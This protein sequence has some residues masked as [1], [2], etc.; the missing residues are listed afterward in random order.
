MTFSCI[1]THPLSVSL[2]GLLTSKQACV[3]YVLK[4]VFKMVPRIGYDTISDDMFKCHVLYSRTRSSYFHKEVLF[5]FKV[6]KKMTI[7]ETPK[8]VLRFERTF[9][10]LYNVAHPPPMS[11]KGQEALD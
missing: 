3:L 4:V 5:I 8:A 10:N 11:K 2:S 7:S 6:D 1:G 9:L